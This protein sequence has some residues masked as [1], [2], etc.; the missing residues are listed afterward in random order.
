MPHKRMESSTVYTLS[1]KV[2]LQILTCMQVL[3]AIQADISFNI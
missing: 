3:H 2:E 1:Q